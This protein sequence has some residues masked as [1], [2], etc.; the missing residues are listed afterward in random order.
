MIA[1]P[2]AVAATAFAA[3]YAAH[4]VADHWV[5]TDQ[6][7]AHKGQSGIV[8][9]WNCFKHVATYTL[10]GLGTV[11]A[12]AAALGHLGQISPVSLAAATVING[13]THYWADR[14]HTL[15]WLA[16]VT[17]HGNFYRLGAP[18]PGHDDNPNLGTGSYVLDQ[19]FHIV[20]LLISAVV[21]AIGA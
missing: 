16:R 11:I 6:Q 19:S 10:I 13:A 20:C 8:G 12:T 18:R 9:H 1:S 7:A 17:A 5:Q 4:M 2:A 21:T 3:L 15:A 14:R